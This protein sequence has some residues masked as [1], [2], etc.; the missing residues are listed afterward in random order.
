ME[1]R[2]AKKSDI[3]KDGHLW[4]DCLHFSV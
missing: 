2:K 4:K 1:Y 3:K